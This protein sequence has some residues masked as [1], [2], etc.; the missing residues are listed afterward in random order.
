MISEGLKFCMLLLEFGTAGN[1]KGCL[2]TRH[3]A[4]DWTLFN[5]FGLGVVPLVHEGD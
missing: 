5:A 4:L 2:N 1:S 3:L